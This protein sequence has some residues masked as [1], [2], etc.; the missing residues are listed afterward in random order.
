MSD[1]TVYLHRD[2][3]VATLTI[4][5]PPLNILDLQTLDRLNDGVATLAAAADLQVVVVRGAGDRAFSAGVAVQDHTPDKVATMLASFHGA[6]RRLRDLDAITAA[7]VHGHAPGGARELPPACDLV[8]A[9]HD[10]QEG[11]RAF[12][13]KRRPVWQH[14]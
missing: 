2:G 14:R 11:L 6:L 12:M 3:R 8:T 7:A 4:N 13:G 1:P 10:M 9:T 5:R